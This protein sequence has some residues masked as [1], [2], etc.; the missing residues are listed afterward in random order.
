MVASRIR[1]WARSDIR[2]VLAASFL[3]FVIALA[4]FAPWVA[5]ADPSFQDYTS[6][7]SPPSA[8]HWLGTDDLGRDVW[9]RIVYGARTS[10]I[11]ATLAVA[12]AVGLGAPT[13]IIAGYIGGWS[14]T[15]SMRVVDTLLSFPGIIL[16]VGIVGVLGPGL[17]NA[18][19]AIGVVFAPNIARIARAESISVRKRLYVD[20][21]TSYGARQGRILFRHIVPNCTQAIIVQ[22]TLLFGFAMLAEASLSFVGLGAQPPTPSWGSMLRSASQ[23]VSRS[24]FGIYPPGIAVALVVFAFNSFGD[25]VRD[26]LDPRRLR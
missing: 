7:M 8:D 13:G 2:G 15:I 10:L 23:F 25:S 17:T 24:S 11:A 12:V 22:A 6:I 21:A 9:A 1:R 14:D 3:L 16:A 19:I 20:A 5:R 4:V 18:M 26:L